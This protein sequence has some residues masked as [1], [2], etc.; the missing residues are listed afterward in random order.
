MPAPQQ[1]AYEETIAAARGS[2]TRGAMLSALSALRRISLHPFPRF[3]DDADFINASARLILAFQ[4]LD[5]VCER[6]ERALIFLDD[7]VDAGAPRRNDSA[8]LSVARAHR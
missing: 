4:I 8:S 2:G 6:H 7:R 1:A 5:D 3:R